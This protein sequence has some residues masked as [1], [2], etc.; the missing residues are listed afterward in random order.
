MRLPSL[1]QKLEEVPDSAELHVDFEHLNYID[2]AC[3]DLLMNWAKQHEGTGGKL[4]LDWESL[5]GRFSADPA[6]QAKVQLAKS[7]PMPMPITI[8][9]P[10]NSFQHQSV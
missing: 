6:E 9:T 3:L 4:V 7:V 5:H 8:N 10:A 2:H 1:A